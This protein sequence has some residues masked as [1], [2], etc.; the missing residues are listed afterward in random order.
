MSEAAP[1]SSAG[2]TWH[3]AQT[4]SHREEL[5][6]AE[7]TKQGFS[8]FLPKYLKQV[9]HARRVSNVAAAL[10]PGY[11]FV[12][13]APDVR[14]R[15]VNGTRG[16]VRLVMAGES[17]APITKDIVEGLIARR[18]ARGYIALPPRAAMRIGDSVRVVGGS[19]ADTLG[20]FE[21]MRDGD[22][23]AI[24]LDLL[25]RKL[26]VVIDEALVEKAA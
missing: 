10:F 3:V 14:W 12:G 4:Q 9:R 21:E 6:A 5:V 8:V 22:R 2:L 25:G 11:L 7:L 1:A 20:L 13:F 24:L 23:V 16:V 26:R 19:F 15:A 17:P 18:D